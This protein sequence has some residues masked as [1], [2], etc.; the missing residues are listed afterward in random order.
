MNGRHRRADPLE[1]SERVAWIDRLLYTWGDEIARDP[2]ALVHLRR[3]EASLR[4][5]TN[6]G[7]FEA[8]RGQNHYSRREIA[9][10]LGVSEIA[11]SKRMHLG[12]T[13]YAALQQLRGA[14]ALVRIGDV[15]R[16]RA[17]GL[18]AAGVQ[19]KTGSEKER[20]AS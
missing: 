3:L 16:E 1:V 11:I 20:K 7:I 13:V 5:N 9:A 2:A 4:D 14:G 17:A 10:V 15:R 6:R 18:A 12:E 8:N 19:D